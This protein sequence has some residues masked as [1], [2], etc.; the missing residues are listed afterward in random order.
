M[1]L[2][3]HQMLNRSYVKRRASKFC[4][5]SHPQTNQK[6][7]KSLV[8]SDHLRGH[9]I[10]LT[11]HTR[12]QILS[13]THPS[14]SSPATQIWWSR[15]QICQG[16]THH[17]YKT[18]HIALHNTTPDIAHSTRPLKMVCCQISIFMIFVT[19]IFNFRI[20]TQYHDFESRTCC[21]P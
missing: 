12:K 5:T 15:N 8:Q 10:S 4:N 20:Y 1:D 2:K 9:I 18:P 6:T 3:A 7:H 11:S 13:H 14:S 21:S 16:T 17:P 19:T